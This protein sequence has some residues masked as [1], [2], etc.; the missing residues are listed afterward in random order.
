MDVDPGFQTV[1][2]Q[3]QPVTARETADDLKQI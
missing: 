3:T 1:S 2:V